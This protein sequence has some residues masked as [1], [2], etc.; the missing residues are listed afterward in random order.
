MI[1]K[2]KPMRKNFLLGLLFVGLLSAGLGPRANG[3]QQ[4]PWSPQE[5]LAP[6]L[7]AAQLQLPENQ[8]PLVLDM[9]PAGRIAGALSIGPA[10]EKAN[11]EQMKKVLQAVDRDREVVVYCGCCPFAKCPNVRP[12]FQTL[13][14][15]GFTKPRL[16]NLSHNLKIDWIDR[17]YPMAAD[18]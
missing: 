8:R 7:L 5:L 17:G 2:N 4:I 11:L 3:Q 12:A 9:G 18:K 6:R 16:L 1:E 14:D 15:M 13:L 10:E